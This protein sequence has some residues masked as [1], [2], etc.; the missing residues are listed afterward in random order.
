M[1]FHSFNQI[2]F[3]CVLSRSSSILVALY[4]ICDLLYTIKL[5]LSCSLYNDQLGCS[6]CYPLKRGRSLIWL[7]LVIILMNLFIQLQDNI[8]LL[9]RARDNINNINTMIN[10]YVLFYSF[11]KEFSMYYYYSLAN[12]VPVF[13]SVY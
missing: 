8:D 6:H 4:V 9:C 7:W 2:L 11:L 12:K 10:E 3:Y 13:I 5:Y 1:G